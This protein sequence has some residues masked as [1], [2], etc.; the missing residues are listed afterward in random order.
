MFVTLARWRL[1]ALYDVR[2]KWLTG[3]LQRLNADEGKVYAKYG[4]KWSVNKFGTGISLVNNKK[5]V[6]EGKM[7]NA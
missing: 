5:S 2:E 3:K 4:F 6:V 7:W 1:R